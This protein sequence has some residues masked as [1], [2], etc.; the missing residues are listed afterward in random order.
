MINSEQ[1]RHEMVFTGVDHAGADELYCPTC[2]R[3]IAVN[4]S[5][6]F[7]KTVIHPGNELAIH[8]AGSSGLTIGATEVTQQE[9]LDESEKVRLDQWE[10]WL[11]EMNFSDLWS[12]DP[13]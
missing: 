9:T 6:E 8:T 2:G 1:E 3:R 5:P 7:Q 10:S 13:S 12:Q 11:A 4:W